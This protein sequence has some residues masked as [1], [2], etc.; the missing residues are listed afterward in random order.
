MTV[1]QSWALALS[2]SCVSVTAGIEKQLFRSVCSGRKRDWHIGNGWR[3]DEDLDRKWL[4][5]L[6]PKY[7]IPSEWGQAE[8]S[9][10][11]WSTSSFSSE[12]NEKH[13][14]F[15]HGCLFLKG[16]DYWEKRLSLDHM[17]TEMCSVKGRYFKTH[18]DPVA[19]SPHALGRILFYFYFFALFVFYIYYSLI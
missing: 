4:L 17:K 11:F 3:A 13:F 16:T 2:H 1:Q 5:W 14:P 12:I 8:I 19:V 9:C 18:S 6:C 15:P 7:E 10:A